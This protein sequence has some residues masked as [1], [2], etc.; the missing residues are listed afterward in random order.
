VGGESSRSCVW[1]CFF[2][3]VAWLCVVWRMVFAFVRSTKCSL[4]CSCRAG[5]IILL[6]LGYQGERMRRK[7]TLAHLAPSSS[8]VSSLYATPNV[9]SGTVVR[10]ARGS[11]CNS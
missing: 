6:L 9:S 7:D 10:T 1:G 5:V 11:S 3:F 2:F 4:L 8:A